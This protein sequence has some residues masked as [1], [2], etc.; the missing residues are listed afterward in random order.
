MLPAIITD[1]QAEIDALCRQHHV[2]RLELFGS[3]AT[4]DWD[5]A[6]S[7]LD[8]LVQFDGK[9]RWTAQFQLQESLRQMLGRDV[10]LIRDREFKNPYFRRSVEASRTHLWG[11]ARQRTGAAGGQMSTHRA[12]QY[13]WDVRREIEFIQRMLVADT[14]ENMLEDEVQFRLARLC[15]ITIGEALNHLSD[16]APETADR[17]TS[18]RGYVDQRNIVVHQYGGIDG[19]LVWD[20]LQDELPL[21]LEEVKALI[22]ELDPEDDPN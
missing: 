16:A 8:F 6:S 18:C 4:G 12:L 11:E 9:P 14:L 5:A 20:T 1:H 15:L 10:D 13:L 3:A 22:T 17:I 7:D 19:Q 2:R 21:L